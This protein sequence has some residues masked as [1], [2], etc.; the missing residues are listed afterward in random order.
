M[1]I[2][3]VKVSFSDCDIEVGD[4]NIRGGFFIHKFRIQNNF[5]ISKNQNN[6]YKL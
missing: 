3:A 5:P 4:E 1:R 6:F 2:Q